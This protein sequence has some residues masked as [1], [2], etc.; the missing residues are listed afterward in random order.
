MSKNNSNRFYAWFF[1]TLLCMAYAVALTGFLVLAD[2]TQWL[3][4]FPREVTMAIFALRIEMMI[5]AL[6]LI[7]AVVLMNVRLH[8][9]S[10][11][12]LT[13][14]S[15]VFLILF[16]GGF[17]N[18]PYLMFKTQQYGARYIS[19]N[20]AEEV[21]NDD[22]EVMVVELNGDARAY[23]HS[24]IIQ[25]HVAGDIVDGKEIVMTFCGL[26]NLGI[27]YEPYVNSRKLELKNMIQL[28]NNLVMFDSESN[29]PIQ[30]IFG[31]LEDGSG[32]MQALPTQMMPWQSFNVLYPQGKVFYNPPDNWFDKLVRKMASDAVNEQH[33]KEQPVF[34][35]IK[36]FDSRLP[37]K[38]MVYGMKVDDDTVAYTKEYL[39]RSNIVNTEIGGMPIVLAYFPEYDTV[40]GF[41]RMQDGKARSISDIDVYGNSS[42]GKL[43]R[44]PVYSKVFWMIW[45]NFYPS[46]R[47]ES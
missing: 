30:Q 32:G 37:S 41:S 43:E 25:P 36:N 18:V 40:S 46:T 10:F 26:S 12:I 1:I 47:L 13:L 8:F 45:S 44:I 17:I 24:Q 11:R 5:T 31:T 28:E 33:D 9:I 6:V 34:P 38:K 21:F 27:A 7:L 2:L 4:Q 42:Y 35:T 15:L 29:Q 16:T 19:V 23:P 14:H 39:M 22:E 3:V 20:E